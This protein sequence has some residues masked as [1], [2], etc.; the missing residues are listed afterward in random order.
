MLRRPLPTR[1]CSGPPPAD[2]NL[3]T[4]PH[5]LQTSDKLTQISFVPS[6]LY[7]P[8]PINVRTDSC[9]QFHSA[10]QIRP[11][12]VHCHLLAGP[13]LTISNLSARNPGDD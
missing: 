6:I 3:V 4:R 2:W 7:S 8:K 11:S 5:R 13:R 10:V 12:S 9:T 1:R